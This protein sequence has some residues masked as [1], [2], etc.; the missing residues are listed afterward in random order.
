MTPVE[1]VDLIASVGFPIVCCGVLFY[2]MIKTS[3]EHK[4]EMVN[5]TTALNNNTLILTEL[6]TEI[7][8]G[9]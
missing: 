2:T 5:I 6:V 3:K 8:K 4:E 9:D 7:R 1:I